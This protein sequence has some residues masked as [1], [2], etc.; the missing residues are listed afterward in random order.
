MGRQFS[1]RMP[2]GAVTALPADRAFHTV[3][4]MQSGPLP[5]MIENLDG[6]MDVFD[7]LNEGRSQ[8]VLG[9]A[10]MKAIAV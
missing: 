6:A 4:R 10:A 9:T 1:R 2:R 5:S 7:A 8:P 3:G